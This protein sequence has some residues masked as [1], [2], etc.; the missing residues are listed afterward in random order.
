ME[1]HRLSKL[2]SCHTSSIPLG[3][4]RDPTRVV[5]IE[6]T[7]E[8]DWHTWIISH[9]LR[10]DPEQ[11]HRSSRIRSIAKNPPHPLIRH[12]HKLS[13]RGFRILG[14]INRVHQHMFSAE[15]QLTATTCTT[16]PVEPNS[17]FVALGD[18]LIDRLIVA[19]E[20]LIEPNQMRPAGL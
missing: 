13:H 8:T 11:L 14:A 12:A 20:G 10:A 1:S 7:H 19:K 9:K 16:E 17:H 18:I 15:D 2:L 3:R 4:A 6:I 5:S